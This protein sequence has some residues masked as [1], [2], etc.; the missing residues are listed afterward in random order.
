[1]NP[2]I[3]VSSRLTG[4]EQFAE[5]AQHVLRD[6]AAVRFGLSFDL[7]QHVLG[8]KATCLSSKRMNSWGSGWIW[9]PRYS[10]MSELQWASRRSWF[11]SRNRGGAM[12]PATMR[13]GNR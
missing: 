11:F 10:S 5:R 9:K 12:R 1:M 2:L 7:R 8:R 4:F 3:Q 13:L 6:A